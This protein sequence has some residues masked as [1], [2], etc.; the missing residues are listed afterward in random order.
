MQ[1]NKLITCSIV[2]QSN[3]DIVKLFIVKNL[4]IVKTF[5]WRDF[6]FSKN[7]GFK[8][9]F[10]EGN[11]DIVKNF[12]W[13]RIFSFKFLMKNLHF[14]AL[15]VV[16]THISIK[17]R[18]FSLLCPIKEQISWW[19]IYA[20]IPL[21]FWKLQLDEKIKIETKIASFFSHLA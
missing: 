8:Q 21:N 16:L 18:I 2:V 20:I 19:R 3:L 14:F 10:S 5:W 12:D 4:D 9:N 6:L 11:L 13:T 1:A 17:E 7:P 15:K